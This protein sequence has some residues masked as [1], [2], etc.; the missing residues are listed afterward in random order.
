M[1][2]ILTA[3]AI[4]LLSATAVLAATPIKPIKQ[5]YPVYGDTAEKLAASM[6]ASSPIRRD[7]HHFYAL[8]HWEVQTRYQ[9]TSDSHGCKLGHVD[10][11]L[12]IKMQL[13]HWDPSQTT[14]AQLQQDWQ[15]FYQALLQHENQHADNGRR[16]AQD[17]A[18][19]LQNFPR[20][21]QCEVYE[22]KLKAAIDSIIHNYK[23]RDQLLDQRTR[24][25]ATEG[26]YFPR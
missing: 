14:D 17:I 16:A 21:H 26:A 25:G 20:H 9:L 8:T 6:T 12:G 22:Q 13:P 15:T 2:R 23:R 19:L 11:K 5:Y 3:C 1:H 4:A 10:V 7:K 18:T 24:H